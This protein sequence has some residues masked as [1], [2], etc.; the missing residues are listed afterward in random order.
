MGPP[1]QPELN[2][3]GNLLGEPVS[4]LY[5]EV[6]WTRRVQ[7]IATFGATCMKVGRNGKSYKRT[8]WMSEGFLW[9][10]G[11]GTRRIPVTELKGVYRGNRSEEFEKM[12]RPT[13]GL[14][15]RSSISKEGAMV[16]ENPNI[17]CVLGTSDRSFSL[18]FPSTE[19]CDE[20]V[21]TIAWYTQRLT[22][23]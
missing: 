10:D 5:D 18:Y 16:K 13:G 15:R 22:W 17:C 3:F 19:L 4:K 14:L 23:A 9:T 11:K 21:E 8:F 7:K 1:P 20:F 2:P 6:T 12:V